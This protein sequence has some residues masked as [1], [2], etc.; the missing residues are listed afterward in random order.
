MLNAFRRKF[1]LDES[2]RLNRI[3]FLDE[4]E[5]WN[6]LMEHYGIVVAVDGFGD[7]GK[8][9][10]ASVLQDSF[11]KGDESRTTGEPGT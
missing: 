11:G 4:V 1:S 2:I 8:R 3:E 5:E 6:M 7:T 10:L 9:V